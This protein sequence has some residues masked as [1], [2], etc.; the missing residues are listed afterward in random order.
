MHQGIDNIQ[1]YITSQYVTITLLSLDID[2]I[3]FLESADVY[4]WPT[5]TEHLSCLGVGQYPCMEGILNLVGK[6]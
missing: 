5:S 2:C 4:Q 6:K 3:C 1:D